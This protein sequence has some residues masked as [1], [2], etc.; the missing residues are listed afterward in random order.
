MTVC[1]NAKSGPHGLTLA[2][3]SNQLRLP[4]LLHDSTPVTEAVV[5]LAVSIFLGD[6]GR[7]KSV[8]FVLTVIEPQD[9]EKVLDM[10]RE[11]ADG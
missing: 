4:A 2:G 5:T 11:P 7:K 9:G 10:F 6:D 1:R 8:P 3:V